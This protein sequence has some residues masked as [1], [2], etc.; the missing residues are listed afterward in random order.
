MHALRQRSL[1]AYDEK[2]DAVLLYSETNVTVLFRPTRSEP[3]FARLT[4]FCGP[5]ADDHGTV[6]VNFNPQKK[7]KSLQAGAFPRK[8]KIIEVKDKDAIEYAP[9]TSGGELI[10]D[11]R[12]KILRIPAPDPGNIVGYEYEVEEQPTL[13]A[14][15]LVLSGNRPSARE[16]LFSPATCRDGNIR[17]HGLTTL[18]SN[19][20]RPVTIRGSGS[21]ERREGNPE[22]AGH[23]AVRDG[24]AGV[25]I[26]S[27]LHLVW[28]SHLKWPLPAG[29]QMGKWYINL[30][31]E[32]VDASPEIKQQVAALTASKATTMQKMQAIATSCSTISVTWRLSWASVASNPIRH[33]DIFSHRYGDCKDKA[34]FG[35][36]HA[37]RDWR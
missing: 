30:V 32:R 2:T 27:L 16:P 15:Y 24:V 1:A 17:L 37:A 33:S 23:A 20:P 21:C 12:Y 5:T 19:Q 22:R 6:K 11:V 10:S 29:T 28:R 26:V 25:M 9:S 18:R 31:G 34:T 8:A 13:L 3:R 14:G 4:R 7:V 36:L 35:A